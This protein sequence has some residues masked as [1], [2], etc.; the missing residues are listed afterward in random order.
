MSPSDAAIAAVL[1]LLLEVSA[2]PK[3][4]NVD[5]EHDF[6]DLKYEHFLA[7]SAASYPV[8]L[9]AAKK[10]SS[11]GKLVLEAVKKTSTWHRGGNV[12]FGA[13]L[14]LIPLVYS[15]NAGSAK[16]IASSAVEAVKSTSVGDSLAV[17]KAFRLSKA[18][19]MKADNLSLEDEKTAEELKRN[20]V[21]LYRW[22][23]M[24]PPEN[25][26]A[27]ELTRGY[28]LS[29]KGM[30]VIMEA[31]DEFRDVNTAVVYTYHTILSSFADPL[32]IAKHGKEVAEEVRQ[33]AAKAVESFSGNLKIFA[34]LDRELI[35]R[36]INPGTAAD[37]TA[38]SIF[39]ALM[40]GVRF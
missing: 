3:A 29:L 36:G 24:A 16:K 12:H 13:F 39:L 28:S 10:Q 2:N 7:S 17:L 19:V 4:G 37:I 34:E 6:D 21:N 9:K 35:T 5:R 8:F 40:E 23:L 18:R 20:N 38:A 33:K 22:M 11:V 30:K 32:I 31:L 27:K 25:V 26:I 1:S 14:L 15:W